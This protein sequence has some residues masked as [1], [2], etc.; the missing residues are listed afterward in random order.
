[1]S[2]AADTKADESGSERSRTEWMSYGQ[3]PETYRGAKQESHTV[4]RREVLIKQPA[5]VTRVERKAH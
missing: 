1:M 3:E 4:P 5:R 2:F